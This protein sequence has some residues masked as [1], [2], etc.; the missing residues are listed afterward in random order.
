MRANLLV[1]AAAIGAG[2]LLGGRPVPAAEAGAVGEWV[3]ADKDA[4]V[5]IGP[6]P[7]RAD[8]LCGA[9]SWLAEPN[10]PATGAAKT[11]IN[12]RDPALRSR[13]I[14]SLPFL[15]G[16]ASDGEGSWGGGT[17]YD[18]RGG[19]TY[20]SKM[21]LEGPDRLAVS[22][23]ILFLCKGETWTRYKP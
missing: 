16:F 7:S 17:I 8:R 22:G 13:P 19:K 11:D 18:P 23:C 21:R 9:I 12:N 15:D 3:V 4:R 5:R 2:C 6:C 20:R 10:D 14:A 1:A